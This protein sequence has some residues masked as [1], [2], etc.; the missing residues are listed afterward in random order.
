MTYDSMSKAERESLVVSMR[1]TYGFAFDCDVVDAVIQNVH[2][3]CNEATIVEPLR[4]VD[5]NVE[6]NRDDAAVQAATT[7]RRCASCGKAETKMK[8]GRCRSVY[9]C[10]RLCQKA[11]YK[12]HKSICR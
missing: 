7:A 9:Y 6:V 2:F 4:E 10:N 12:R 3:T 1:E 8:C 11:D 5:V